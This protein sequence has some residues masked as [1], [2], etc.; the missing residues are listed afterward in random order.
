MD[1]EQIIAMMEAQGYEKCTHEDYMTNVDYIRMTNNNESLYFKPKQVFPIVFE[2]K[3][4][5]LKVYKNGDVELY[6]N[7]F[8][9]WHFGDGDSLPLLEQAMNE[10]KRLRGIKNV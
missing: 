2:N 4:I 8:T 5:G 1:K 9:L 6:Q 10:S 7:G 3:S